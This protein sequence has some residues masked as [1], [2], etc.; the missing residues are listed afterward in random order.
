M[1]TK[2]VLLTLIEERQ[3]AKFQ[4]NDTKL[5]VNYFLKLDSLDDVVCFDPEDGGST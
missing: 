1:L 2:Y 5:S 3:H 4:L